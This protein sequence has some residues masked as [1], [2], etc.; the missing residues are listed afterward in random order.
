[1]LYQPTYVTPS[2]QWGVG[3]GIVDITQGLTVGWKVNGE[4]A[5][6]AFSVTIYQ[7]N[8][9]STQVYT[10]GQLTENCPFYGTDRNGK[11]VLFSYT[12]PASALS[13]AGMVNGGAYKLII[14]QWWGDG[15]SI[16]QT[17]ASAFAT[18]SAPVLTLGDIP[19]PL[20]SRFYT[21]TADFSQAQGDVV[22]L[23]RWQIAGADG[24]DEPFYDTGYIATPIL[25]TYYDGFFP[26]NTYAVKCDVQTSSGVSVSTG[27]VEYSVEYDTSPLTGFVS[28]SC[29]KNMSAVMVSWP[30]AEFINGEGEGA[31]TVSGG[32]LNINKGGQ[33]S[34]SEISG[35]AM[36]LS[37]P[38]SVVWQGSLLYADAVLFSVGGVSMVYTNATQRLALVVD[39]TERAA[40]TGVYGSDT[41][42]LL[43]T[44]SG[45][46]LRR[47]NAS[48]GLLPSDTLLPSETLYPQAA[49][50]SA[51]G[52]YPAA[53]TQETFTG[54]SMGAKQICYFLQVLEDDAGDS[55]AADIIYA[56]GYTPAFDDN[57]YMLA[58]FDKGLSAG[59]LT[60]AGGSTEG[61]AIYRRAE[62]ETLLRHIADVPFGV[63]TAYDYGARSGETY[64]YYVLPTGAETY[65]SEPLESEAITPCWWNWTVLS[66]TERDDGSYQVAEQFDFGKNLSSGSISNN[67]APAIFQNFTPYPTVQKAPQNYRSGTL[68]SLIGV[69]TKGR[70]TDSRQL[71]DA[72]WA[73]SVSGNTLFLKSRKGDLMQIAISGAISM[74]TMDNS[75]AQA[76]TVTL[77]WV[78]VAAVDKTEIVNY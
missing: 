63:K 66:C 64:T 32:Q 44:P 53:Y 20:T 70:Y 11:P 48:G 77:P 55:G 16:A 76:Q 74:T 18:R 4:S 36:A 25:E 72:I 28:V 10:T 23:V 40:A 2:D 54:I 17:S 65:P 26:G 29:A 33:V 6:T 3:N 47:E 59:S 35:E 37:A 31:Y 49:T 75:R 45:F 22:D 19:A 68:E 52:Y 34:W 73:L 62:G 69:I 78:E 1:M 71:R 15:E 58:N 42:T 7:N 14:E 27:W 39:G 24:T 50:V 12:I 46:Y 60:A 8:A 67:N 51:T 38:W 30:Q 13:E 56:D 61:V 9:T 43:L 41:I 57:T 5:M 21:F